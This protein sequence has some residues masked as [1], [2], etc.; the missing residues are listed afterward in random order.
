MSEKVVKNVSDLAPYAKDGILEIAIRNENSKFKE[1]HK[2]LLSNEKV[3]EKAREI[4]RIA[5][6]PEIKAA[7]NIAGNLTALCNVLN[8]AATVANIAV[9]ATGFKAMSRQLDEGFALV[10]ESVLGF[11]SKWQQNEFNQ[12]IASPLDDLDSG[13]R[14][15]KA[16]IEKGYEVKREKLSALLSDYNSFFTTLFRNVEIYDMMGEVIRILTVLIPIYK[17]LQ[18]YY[19]ENFFDHYGEIDPLISTSKTC[20]ENF[21]GEEFL[22]SAFDYFA[23]QHTDAKGKLIHSSEAMKSVQGFRECCTSFIEKIANVIALRSAAGSLA[24]YRQ[25]VEMINNCVKERA[26][27]IYDAMKKADVENAEQVF[28][29][30]VQTVLAS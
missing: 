22:N 30:A 3:Q 29:S 10:R 28:S 25:R 16:D 9:T 14:E 1:F 2:V 7:G 24:V 11:E 26:E 12:N 6:S 21:R 5:N 18:V 15:I 20:I 27:V 4:Q 17:E 13:T 8:L 23:L 19:F